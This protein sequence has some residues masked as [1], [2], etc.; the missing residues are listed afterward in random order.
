MAEN[1]RDFKGVWIPKTVWL[2]SRL[3]PN[4]KCYLA[5][6]LQCDGIESEAD[7]LMRQVVTKTTVCA[8]KKKLRKLQLI[9]VVTSSEQAKSLVLARKGLGQECEWCGTRT[10]ALQE[11]HYPIPQHKGGTETVLICQNCHY[12]FHLLLKGEE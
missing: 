11:H 10:V 1:Q 9:S 12:E 4:E 6:Y 2:D 7:K 5:V 8:I 3:S